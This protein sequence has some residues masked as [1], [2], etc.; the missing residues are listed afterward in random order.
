MS[1]SP[2]PDAEMMA[3]IE[4]LAR[5]M[6][7]GDGDAAAIFASQGVTILDNRPPFI[8]SGANAAKRWAE[9]FGESHPGYLDLRHAF[10][11]PQDF[12]ALGDQA[13]VSLPTTWTWRRDGQ[14]FHETGG[15]AF[16]LRREAGAW[17]IESHGWAVTSFTPLGQ[18][19]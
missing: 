13:Y 14:A 19:A 11:P 9:R 3:P 18:Y 8:F 16:V 5:L 7:G 12:Q 1:P 10:G 2:T 6:A 4:A 17:R 15:W